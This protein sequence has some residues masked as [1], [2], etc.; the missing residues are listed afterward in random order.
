MRV[1]NTDD[2]M[3]IIAI[4]PARG[5]SKSIPRKNLKPLCG[6]PLI[7]FI[8][9]TARN[10][11]EI[12]RVIVSTDDDE[13]AEVS[14]S[15]GA[16]VPFMRPKNL[17][18]DET[19]TLPVLQHAITYLE[20]N[21]DYHPDVVVLLYA[22]TPLITSDRISEG[23]NL[24]I[25]EDYDSV[26]SVFEDLGHFWME[27]EAG[28]MERYLPKEITNRQ[29]TKPIFRENGALYIAREKILMED[30]V[31]VGGRVGLLHFKKGE[32]IDI[33]DPVDFEITEFLF[34]RRSES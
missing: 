30:C 20:T 3:N 13:I 2:H 14:K 25:N 26:I 29:Y 8:I 11:P 18:R 10:V 21:E 32:L 33:D 17:A 24:L 27:N 9:E 1:I 28:Q 12:D 31:I 34:H 7:S 4:I 22:T 5:G 6:K 19:P 23:I 16:E 15:L